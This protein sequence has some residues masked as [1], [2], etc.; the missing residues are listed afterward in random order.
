MNKKSLAEYFRKDSSLIFLFSGLIGGSCFALII[1]AVI[2]Y[3]VAIISSFVAGFG[4]FGGMAVIISSIK[5]SQK[6]VLRHIE[7]YFEALETELKSS[8]NIRPLTTYPLELG[9]TNTGFA[10]TAHFLEE[11]SAKIRLH[12]PAL[13]VE[14]GSGSST[15][16]N[17]VLLKAMGNGR[18]ISMDDDPEY[19]EITRA[20]IR[21]ENVEDCAEVIL[22][23][24][25]SWDI[26]EQNWEWYDFDP[27]KHIHQPID[28]LIV[29]GPPAISNP[30]A[31]YPAVPILCEYLSPDC[32]IILDDGK[33]ADEKETARKW[34]ALL[35]AETEYKYRGRGIWFLQRQHN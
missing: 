4:V 27:D 20:R 3:W 23:P 25:R 7:R 31:R 5:K 28:M 26:E 33:R 11:V 16:V 21:D 32:I 6:R 1:S 17:A 18:I 12:N 8:V 30:L 22:A 24:I 9:N 15:I 2:S 14:C 10:A 19:A 35:D 13:I 29:D 34:A